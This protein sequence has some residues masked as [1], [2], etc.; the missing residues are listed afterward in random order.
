[1]TAL[2]S[3]KQHQNNFQKKNARPKVKIRFSVSLGKN[4]RCGL[5]FHT[6]NKVKR[7]DDSCLKVPILEYTV[8]WV[9]SSPERSL[10]D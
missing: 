1:M 8:L 2:L 6:P 9:D 3:M 7:V 4:R 10:V 5:S